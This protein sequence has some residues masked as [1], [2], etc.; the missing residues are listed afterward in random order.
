L[1]DI[2]QAL[3]VEPSVLTDGAEAGLIDALQRASA[4]LGG[5]GEAGRAD[6]FA[7][8]FP[9][10]AALVSEQDRRIGQ[11]EG[12]LDVLADRL[13]HDPQLATALHEVISAVTSIRST[14]S[15]LAG[16]EALD[17]DWQRRFHGN[18][19]DDSQRLAESSQALVA[20]L[21]SAENETGTALLPQEEVEAFFARRGYWFADLDE[22]AQEGAAK[23]VIRGI[24]QADDAPEGAI[25]RKILR[26]HLRQYV[27]DAKALP[28]Q[29]FLRAVETQG[30]D[31]DL[32]AREFDADL[33][34]V[35]RR[36]AHLPDDPGRSQRGLAIC[37]M[38]G[39]LIYMTPVGGF[40]CRVPPGLVRAGRSIRPWRG[41]VIRCAPMWRCRAIRRNG[42]W[43]MPWPGP[44]SKVGLIMHL[45]MR[46]P[47]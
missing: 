4:R 30:V 45:F 19:H 9:G 47:C 32:L 26:A 12:Q 46:R 3:D 2:A 38:S 8:R 13:A 18:L 7:G 40:I 41:P 39:A 5:A 27:R 44:R 10:W 42:F 31:P 35:L 20:Y 24:L 23:K 36:L 37:D 6:E 22:A 1:Q 14:A 34:C 29:P 33:D 28:F 11:L 25:A 43:P 15:I 21:D 17:Q 16:D